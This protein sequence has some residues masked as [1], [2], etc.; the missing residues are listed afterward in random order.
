MRKPSKTVLREEYDEVRAQR[1]RA[2]C[3]LNAILCGQASK[4]YRVAESIHPSGVPGN[5]Y[6]FR[7]IARGNGYDIAVCTFRCDSTGQADSTR[8]Y[9]D[10][11]QREYANLSPGNVWSAIYLQAWNQW[12]SDEYAKK[13]EVS[14]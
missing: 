1:D 12:R 13:Q 8:V 3:A 4:A 5:S 14:K 9:D 6:S 11:T 10:S 2:D 7:F